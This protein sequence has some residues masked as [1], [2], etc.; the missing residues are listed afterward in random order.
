VRKGD[1]LGAIA[2]D[3]SISVAQLERWN[4]DQL[5]GKYLL[6]GIT[7]KVYPPASAGP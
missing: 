5:N 4:A 2:R 3:F 6:P 7:L 1:T